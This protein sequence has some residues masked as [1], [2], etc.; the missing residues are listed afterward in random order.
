MTYPS[1]GLK[2]IIRAAIPGVVLRE[3]DFSGNSQI[4]G[5]VFRKG[6]QF[7]QD[8]I[9][10]QSRQSQPSKTFTLAHE[11]GHYMLNHSPLHN[12]LIDDRQFDGSSVMQDE[13]EANFFAMALLMPK[14]EFEKV[15]I[16]GISDSRIA[17]YFGV[18]EGNVKVRRS[19]LK[20]NGF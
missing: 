6:A 9:A 12:F 5:A 7:P 2:S 20:S 3:D 13:G 4:K 15:D 16:H 10:I 14:D 18:T 11:F 1:Y 19:W 17:N 8:V